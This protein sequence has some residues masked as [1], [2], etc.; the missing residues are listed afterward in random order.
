MTISSFLRGI[1]WQPG[2]VLS[3]W[4][5]D[6]GLSLFKDI[7]KPSEKWFC[8]EGS[9]CPCCE[10]L[11]PCSLCHLQAPSWTPSSL[12]SCSSWCPAAF[13][14]S[15]GW[16]PELLVADFSPLAALSQATP[17]ALSGSKPSRLP[18]FTLKVAAVILTLQ[19]LGVF[20]SEI[21]RGD[22]DSPPS[23]T[24]VFKGEFLVQGPLEDQP[25]GHRPK[26]HAYNATMFDL[27]S[28]LH[29]I[30]SPQQWSSEKT[31][32]ARKTCLGE[33]WGRLHKRLL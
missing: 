19:F 2:R 31:L 21:L 30:S 5:L 24:P 1:N 25:P 8:Y 22:G 29:N 18:I 27:A 26:L 13:A 4:T 20:R 7:A 28:L 17:A 33:G 23:D 16:M 10:S 9:F 3:L 15:R 12:I 14:F 6:P 32:W 11:W